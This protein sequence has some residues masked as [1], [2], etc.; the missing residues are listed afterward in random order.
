MRDDWKRC[1]RALR[2]SAIN[3]DGAVVAGFS[4]SADFSSSF[5]GLLLVAI[6]VDGAVLSFGLS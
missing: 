4:E 6:E 5:F 1:E 2:R 3:P